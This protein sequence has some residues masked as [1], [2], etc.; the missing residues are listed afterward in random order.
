MD[1]EV[2]V[3]NLTRLTC[4]EVEP[5]PPKPALICYQTRPPYLFFFI[6]DFAYLQYCQ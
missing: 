4:T 6:S 5:F 3:F 1:A 2:F